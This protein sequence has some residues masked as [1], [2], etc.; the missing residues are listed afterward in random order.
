MNKNKRSEIFA[1]FRDA[2]PSPTT[3]LEFSSPFELLIA[4]I[5]SAR[6]PVQQIW[7]R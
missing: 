2:D 7:L 3:E 6:L 4:A 5:L 1:R